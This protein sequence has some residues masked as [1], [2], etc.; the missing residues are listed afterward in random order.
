MLSDLTILARVSQPGS[1]DDELMREMFEALETKTISLALLFSAQVF[2]HIHHIL[3]GQV[4]RGFED[5]CTIGQMAIDSVTHYLEFEEHHRH[6]NWSPTN[7][8]AMRQILQQVKE[9]CENDRV[10]DERLGKASGDN[11][12]T[13]V[14]KIERYGL[15]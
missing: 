13:E 10:R 8:S 1:V 4:S 7:H 12:L 11:Q 15:Q 2:L 6:P 3:R 9:S 14:L 5:L